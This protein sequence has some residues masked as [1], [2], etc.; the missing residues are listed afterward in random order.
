TYRDI[1]PRNVWASGRWGLGDRWSVE[2]RYESIPGTLASTGGAAGPEFH[3]RTWRVL[4]QYPPPRGRFPLLGARWYPL[5]ELSAARATLPLTEP[6]EIGTSGVFTTRLKSAS[7]YPAHL[8]VNLIGLLGLNW[9]SE[10][11][12]HWGAVADEGDFQTLRANYMING[13]FLIERHLGPKWRMGAH[14]HGEAVEARFIRD[15][16]HGQS[17]FFYSAMELTLSRAF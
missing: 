9:T 4:G 13:R 15:S 2:A 10:F 17:Q 14:W 3:W 5:L 16:L 6:V 12:L 8:G 1:R 7:A 11:A